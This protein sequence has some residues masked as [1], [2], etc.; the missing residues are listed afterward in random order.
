[1]NRN[2]KIFDSI[3]IKKG[4]K[5][6]KPEADVPDCQWDGCDL[7]GSHKAP[8]GRD[9]EGQ[10]VH[11]CIE[12]VREYNKSYN[13]FSGLNDDDI[14]R[15]RKDALTGHRPTWTMGVNRWGDEP[16]LSD[17]NPRAAAA[18]RVTARTRARA[19]LGPTDKNPARKLKALEK[20]AFDDLGVAHFAPESE[21][22]PLNRKSKPATKL[23]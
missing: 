15:F 19:G 10:Y 12:H 2:S 9:R 16:P 22:S 11:F 6:K 8:L 14:A 18:A 17:G 3:Q 7:P 23:W 21:I 5:A 4:S 1:M 13:Y 20:K